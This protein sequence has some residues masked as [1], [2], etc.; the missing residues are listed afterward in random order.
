[1][2]GVMLSTTDQQENA[3][4]HLE[5][6][7]GD[8]QMKRSGM[9]APPGATCVGLISFSVGVVSRGSVK[10]LLLEGPVL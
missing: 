7:S 5:Q 6:A 8:A 10:L 9:Y 3:L 1:M 4:H 2:A